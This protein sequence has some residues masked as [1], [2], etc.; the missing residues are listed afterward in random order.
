MRT[1]KQVGDALAAFSHQVM[2]YANR[3]PKPRPEAMHSLNFS[4][5]WISS[6]A[7]LLKHLGVGIRGREPTPLRVLRAFQDRLWMTLTGFCND[8]VVGAENGITCLGGDPCRSN[9]C[10]FDYP[11]GYC[12]SFCDVSSGVCPGDGECA[13]IFGSIGADLGLCLDGCLVQSDCPRMGYSCITNPYGTGSV[14]LAP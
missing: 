3:E 14:C 7:M 11:D 4:G 1:T 12:V 6:V 10:S 13:D 5:C 8:P 2:W 9:Y